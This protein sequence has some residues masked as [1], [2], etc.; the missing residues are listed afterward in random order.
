MSGNQTG[1]SGQKG[2]SKDPK[3]TVP[4]Q[5]PEPPDLDKSDHPGSTPPAAVIT[6]EHNLPEE[7][8]MANTIAPELHYQNLTQSRING[9]SGSKDS[10]FLQKCKKL[11]LKKRDQKPGESLKDF[12]RALRILAGDCKFGNNT[13]ALPTSTMLRDRFVAGLLDQELQRHLCRRHEE[14]AIELTLEKALEIG[15]SVE[16]TQKLQKILKNDDNNNNTVKKTNHTPD[17]CKF[18]NTVCTYCSKLGHIETACIKKKKAA[19]GPENKKPTAKKVEVHQDTDSDS[20]EDIMDIDNGADESLINLQT[21]AKIWPHAEPRWSNRKPNLR[22][23]GERPIATK[24]IMMVRVPLTRCLPLIITSEEE[25]PNLFGENWF[26]PLG[27]IV[28]GIQTVQLTPHTDYMAIVDKFPGL[29]AETPSGHAGKPIHIQ[30]KT[31]CKPKFFKARRIPLGMAEM[32]YEA[33]GD[34]EKQN[35]ITPTDQSD[36]TTPVLFVPKK[37]ERKLRVVGD[38]KVTVNPAITNSEYPLPTVKE[39]MA[40]LNG[41][42]I[43]SQIDLK[44]A[45]KQIRVDPDTSKILTISIPKGLYN[46]NVMLDGLN[47][48]PRIF[49]KFMETHLQGIH[50]VLIYLDNI[51]IQGRTKTEH[52]DRLIEVLKR[53]EAANL[54]INKE[55]CIFGVTEMEFLGYLVSDIGV[56]PLKDKV[57]SI[58]K[59]PTPSNV[60][61][62]KVFL[63]G[64]NFYADFIKDRARIAEPLHRLLDTGRTWDWNETHQHAFSELKNK[65][66][67]AP[68]L[69][70]FDDE[71]E[72][73]VSADASPTGIGGVLAVI[74]EDNK[75]HPVAYFS[76]TLTKTQRRYS[77]LDREA[78]ELVEIV[79]HFHYYLAGRKFLL[80]TDHKPLCSIFNPNKPTPEIIS[81][82]LSRYSA[83]LSAYKYD[84]IHRPGNKHTNVDLLSRLPLEDTLEDE[85]EN[86]QENFMIENV[87]KN[88]V[89]PEDIAK[90]TSKDETL[91]QVKKWLVNGW[92]SKVP[93]A[94]KHYWPKRNEMSLHKDCILWGN[95]VVIPEELRDTILQYLHANHPG[96]CSTKAAARSY[97]W[98][99]SIDDNI[100]NMTKWLEVKRMPSTNSQM[101]IKVLRGLFATFGLPQ[102]IVS[103]NGTAFSSN[104]IKEFYKKNGIKY[105]YI[106]PYHPESNGQA[107]RMVQTTIRSLNKLTEGNWEIKLPRLRCLE[108]HYAPL[109]TLSDQRK[110]NKMMFKAQK[111]VNY[112]LELDYE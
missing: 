16:G 57:K 60:K 72:I 26:K 17:N 29:M 46:V 81:P 37:L 61:D 41:G 65:L 42:K 87:S 43:F 53:L 67:S 109:W 7:A 40:T 15:S 75:E 22:A 90:S 80:Y 70:H 74:G 55:K 35:M 82:K 76:R 102:T 92:P 94:Y 9:R 77:Q 45:Y 48:A 112:R 14:S 104:E 105:L 100:E 103:D 106:A 25:G 12:E 24:G 96:I 73:V 85:E 54:I 52:N 23:W 108:D 10:D 68:I 63:G 47:I 32:V 20:F 101:V 84:L 78:L 19:K 13:E 18:R 34:M 5:S 33:L 56:R 31:E 107:E 39:A 50:G 2:N 49:Q 71:R 11:Q 86:Y 36:W 62:L 51:K 95:R 89:T 91:T 3:A 21:F 8:T 110:R 79:K 30:I 98:W 66:I 83:T 27:I 4:G 99:P 69:N 1:K 58:S 6:I 64:L 44:N 28:T 97:A 38:Y 59:M 111:Y 93:A 88:P